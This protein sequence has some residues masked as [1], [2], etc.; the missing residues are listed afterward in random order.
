MVDVHTVT[1]PE[2]SGGRR[3]HWAHVAVVALHTLCC[4]L[5]LVASL[6]GL[7]ASAALMGGVLRF[8]TFL[9]GRELWLLGV[10]ASLVALGAFAEWRFTRGGQQ[11][12]SRMFAV[13]VACFAFNAAII[14]GHRLGPAPIATAAI[15]EQAH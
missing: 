13:S 1:T 8:H 6:S 12:V 11:R 15:V 5:P 2:Q 14:A 7:A 3:T 9:H 10:S 4:G